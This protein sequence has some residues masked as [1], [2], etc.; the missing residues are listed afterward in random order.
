MKIAKYST[1]P[2]LPSMDSG[3]KERQRKK[4]RPDMIGR[5]SQLNLTKMRGL[6]IALYAVN[7]TPKAMVITPQSWSLG[8]KPGLE[9]IAAD[10]YP[11]NAAKVNDKK[12]AVTR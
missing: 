3:L 12:A 7:A 2:T 5:A 11:T 1:I 6:F 9:R 10:G 4:K 8:A